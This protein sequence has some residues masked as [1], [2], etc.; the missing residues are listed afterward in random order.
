MC[1]HDSEK[2][3]FYTDSSIPFVLFFKRKVKIHGSKW[4]QRKT[5]KH[6]RTEKQKI[7]PRDAAK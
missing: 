1:V 2:W 5:L 7:P 3:N 4:Y 6:Y